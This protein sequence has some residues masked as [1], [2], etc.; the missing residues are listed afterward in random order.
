MPSGNPVCC[1]FFPHFFPRFFLSSAPFPL[2][3]FSG[4][5]QVEKE[6]KFWRRIGL[7]VRMGLKGI[8]RQTREINPPYLC[9]EKVISS[10]ASQKTAILYNRQNAENHRGPVL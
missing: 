4:P 6:K 9:P 3:L 1:T 2:N 7:S 8:E 10:A 5:I